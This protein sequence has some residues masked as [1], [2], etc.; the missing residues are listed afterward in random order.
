VSPEFFV[1]NAEN[2]NNIQ[3]LY[4]PKPKIEINFR[5]LVSL[6]IN[7]FNM[8]YYYYLITLQMYIAFLFLKN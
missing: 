6:K 8:G 5:I 1:S 3:S 2:T 4:F 7:I